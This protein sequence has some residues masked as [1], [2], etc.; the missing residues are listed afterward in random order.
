MAYQ[1]G[2]SKDQ[3]VAPSTDSRLETKSILETMDQDPELRPVADLF[4]KAKMDGYL[5]GPDLVTVFAPRK[6]ALPAAGKDGDL[7]SLLRRHMLGRAVTEDALR[8]VDAVD[9]L[10]GSSVSIERRNA[11]T[12]VAGAK[13]VRPDVECTNGVIHV[14]DKALGN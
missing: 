14:V 6:D 2:T 11:E 4:R 13:I 7:N 3:M 5:G 8:S 9:T 12:L 10:D 1:E